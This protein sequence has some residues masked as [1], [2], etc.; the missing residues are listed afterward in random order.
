MSVGEIAKK[1]IRQKE[2]KQSNILFIGAGVSV[3]SGI[4]TAPNLVT[5]VLQDPDYS[6]LNNQDIE[7]YFDLMSK[8]DPGNRRVILSEFIDKSKVNISHF[9][10]GLLMSKGIIDCVLTT[11]FDP[12]VKR[13]TQ[14]FYNDYPVYDV[15]NNIQLRSHKIHIPSIIH[16]H[17]RYRNVLQLNTNQELK[18]EQNFEKI[19]TVL[20]QISSK[21]S[22]WIVIGYSG[23][24]P[25]LN[26]LAKI[27]QFNHGLYWV[28]YKDESP[29]PKVQNQLLSDATKKTKLVSGYNS[30]EFFAT[31]FNKL[32]E[33]EELDPTSVGNTLNTI[34]LSHPKL[35][36]D[37][38]PI[39]N[40]KANNQIHLTEQCKKWISQKANSLIVSEGN[41]QRSFTHKLKKAFKKL[42]TNERERISNIK[43]K[44][45]DQQFDEA[46]KLCETELKEN[47]DSILGY[48]F[49]A[50]ALAELASTNQ[51]IEKRADYYEQMKESFEK[52]QNLTEYSDKYLPEINRIP[53]VKLALWQNEFQKGVDLA[54][55]EDLKQ[56][57]ENPYKKSLLHLRIATDLRPDK[58]STWNVRAQIAARN[59]KFKE[60]VSAKEK[61]FKLASE[62]E[63]DVVDYLHLGNYY[64]N[65]NK[66]K[67]VVEVFE[68][69]QNRYPESEPIVTNLAD[70][71]SR[72]GNEEE[73]ISTLEKLV[74]KD[75]ENPQYRLVMGTKIYQQ[76]LRLRD[77]VESNLQ[78]I[79]ELKNKHKQANKAEK[80]EIKSKIKS[81]TRDNKRIKHAQERLSKKAEKEI[82]KAL[83]YRPDDPAAYETLGVIY[84]NKAK[85]CFDLKNRTTDDE[86][87]KKLDRVGKEN[88]HQAINYYENAVEL[89]PD[90]Q[91]Y[92]ES[93]HQLY[94]FSE[95]YE[96]A[97]EALNHINIE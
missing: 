20:A 74:D 90:N 36:T 80:E 24:D 76:S 86:E 17:G 44:L 3:T 75:S 88:I 9:I 45:K 22:T 15:V 68:D 18:K 38:N 10:I 81:L 21:E 89:E 71:Y 91:N 72:A 95:M 29:I 41:K 92:W 35:Q 31:L 32:I 34:F 56:R 93:L 73:A 6:H 5:H 46:L 33:L 39:P 79:I 70:A 1:L 40:I 65:L 85:S 27:R 77:K 64:Y 57:I 97:N 62:A 63:I 52:A 94:I 58:P 84:Q 60:A 16:L 54:T 2:K 96:K 61:Y 82:Q 11:N 7:N 14:L 87:S 43:L 42:F 28:G 48:Y 59:N 66:H 49:K 4:P 30:D 26:E 51:E 12:L 25:I 37:L 8:L 13:G 50:V 67:K 19:K 55:D 83:E 23:D 69:G 47:K 78:E 53:A